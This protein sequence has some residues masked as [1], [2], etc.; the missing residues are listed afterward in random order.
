[1]LLKPIKASINVFLNNM[2]FHFQRAIVLKK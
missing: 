1:M 2:L